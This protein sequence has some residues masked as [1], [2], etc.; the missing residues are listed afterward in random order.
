MEEIDWLKQELKLYY[1]FEQNLFIFLCWT[2][3]HLRNRK[4]EI[5]CIW[6]GFKVSKWDVMRIKKKKVGQVVLKKEG[7]RINNKEFWILEETLFLIN[8]WI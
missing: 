3:L 6:W 1:E 2:K 8:N 4:Y 7:H 5:I